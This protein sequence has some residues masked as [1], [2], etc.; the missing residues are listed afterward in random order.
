MKK[1]FPIILILITSVTWLMAREKPKFSHAIHKEAEVECTT[2]H[3]VE[4][5]TSPSDVLYPSMETCY[6]CHDEGLWGN[7]SYQQDVPHFATGY[8]KKFSHKTHIG[9]D[10]SCQECHV[11]VENSEM[12]TDRFLPDMKQCVQCHETSDDPGYCTICHSKKDDL[13]PGSHKMLTWEKTHGIESQAQLSNCVLCHTTSSCAECHEGDNLDHKVHPLN[14]QYNHGLYAR[15]NKTNCLTCH[16]E[17]SSCNSCH[18][19]Q[20]VMPTSHSF[21]NWSNPSTGGKHAR[22][23][24]MDLDN[25][26]SC[27]SDNY[28]EPICVQCHGK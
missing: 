10:I 16:E 19:E 5:S 9:K 15:S 4:S 25:C 8:I 20:L 2:C 3:D 24:K 12:I 23:A 22:E 21:A 14:Y 6:E 18:R 7:F 17:E 27:H 1:A 26:I 11:G 13:S 28:G